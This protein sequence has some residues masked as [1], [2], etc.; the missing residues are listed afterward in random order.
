VSPFCNT[1]SVSHLVLR[2][3]NKSI[4]YRDMSHKRNTPRWFRVMPSVGL[5]ETL[6][7]CRRESE[8]TQA[9]LAA[10]LGVDRTTVVRTEA[11]DVAALKRVVAAFSV[12][13]Y[14]L[15]ALPKGADVV[16]SP[17]GER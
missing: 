13:G 11:S 16:V 9:E 3:C 4:Q 17:R 8:I 6:A 15:V 2:F 12:L 1:R 10:R 14:E 5:G 7:R